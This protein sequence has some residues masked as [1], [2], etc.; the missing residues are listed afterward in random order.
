MNGWQFDITDSGKA[1]LAKLD[2]TNRNRVLKKL[3]WFT[4]NFQNVTPFPLGNIWKG[5]FKLR[6]GEWRIVYEVDHE[7]RYIS[8]HAIDNRDSVYQQKRKK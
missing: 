5:C 3:K 2:A 1:D 6:A 4:E 7:R 8:V